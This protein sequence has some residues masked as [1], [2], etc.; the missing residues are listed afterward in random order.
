VLHQK[1]FAL[2]LWQADGQRRLVQERKHVSVHRSVRVGSALAVEA[3][4]GGNQFVVEFN[5]WIGNERFL[6]L[7]QQNHL[8]RT[9]C[10]GKL[11]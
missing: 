6:R 7:W 11:R 1:V 9:F 2:V 5:I 8:A 4:N 10:D 3:W